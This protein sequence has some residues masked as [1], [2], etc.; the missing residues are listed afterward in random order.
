[1]IIMATGKYLS[2]GEAIKK[3]DLKA[4]AKAHPSKGDKDLFDRLFTAM[5][6]KP[7]KA[8]RTSRKG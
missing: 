2:L 8:G 3:K 4:F 5:A 1:M 7:S 6:K